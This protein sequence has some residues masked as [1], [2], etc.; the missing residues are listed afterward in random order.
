MTPHPPVNQALAFWDPS[1]SLPWVALGRSHRISYFSSRCTQEV[2]A[3]TIWEALGSWNVSY[4]RQFC[5]L[6]MAAL[7][8]ADL[9][10]I[11]SSTAPCLPSISLSSPVV[12]VISCTTCG[13]KVWPVPC[14]VLT[15][16]R[17]AVVSV[18]HGSSVRHLGTALPLG[19]GGGEGAEGYQYFQAVM[20]TQGLVFQ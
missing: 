12:L 14:K 19:G 16:R 11:I 6:R 3:I 5:L 7:L 15:S 2:V 18:P 13:G 9:L 17:A 4:V 10:M 8:L 20:E 1:S